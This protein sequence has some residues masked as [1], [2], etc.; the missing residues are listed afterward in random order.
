M[1]FL[2]VILLLLSSCARTNEIQ[3]EDIPQTESQN[4]RVF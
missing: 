4:K 3:I 1:K 2:I